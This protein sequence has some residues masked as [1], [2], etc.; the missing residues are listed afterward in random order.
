MTDLSRIPSPM[1][2]LVEGNE[3]KRFSL[4]S[5]SL[6]LRLYEKKEVRG[7]ILQD[8]ICTF[9]CTVYKLLKWQESCVD[10][11]EYGVLYVE[12]NDVQID[13]IAR[14]LCTTSYLNSFQN[15]SKVQEMSDTM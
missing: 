13:L 10:K 9:L 3:Q 5:F 1:H 7:N 12:T 14:I 15:Y 4:P 8:E 2:D 6:Y 11:R